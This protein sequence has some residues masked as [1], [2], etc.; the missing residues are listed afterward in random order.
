MAEPA[1]PREPGERQRLRARL[2][3]FL[4]FR[5]LAAQE[6]F[7]IAFA[8]APLPEAAGGALSSSDGGDPL[9]VRK[10]DNSSEVS[11]VTSGLSA[12]AFRAWLTPVWPEALGLADEDLLAT[13]AQA[14]RLYVN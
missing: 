5:V 13:L 9:P 12:S 11:G 3:E 4:K 2:L 8:G 6:E 10:P 14:H 7:F 1:Q